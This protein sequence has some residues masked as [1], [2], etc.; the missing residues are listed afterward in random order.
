M[1][2]NTRELQCIARDIKF[3]NM[4]AARLERSTTSHRGM[5]TKFVNLAT[6]IIGMLQTCPSQRAVQKLECLK[7]QIDWKVEDIE[8][9]YD[10]LL[11][12]LDPE[13]DEY[14]RLNGLVS[15]TVARHADISKSVV[16]AAPGQA[17]GN[18]VKLKEGLKP[19]VL[20]LDF[21]PLEFQTWQNKFRIYYR[22]SRMNTANNKEQRSYFYSCISVHL[23]SVITRNTPTRATIFIEEGQQDESCF[24]G[25]AREFHK[26]TLSPHAASSFS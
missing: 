11:A 10:I 3:S 26:N 23:Q 12:D 14:K 22:T 24:E 21:S 4:D 19:T 1:Y 13:D 25:L 6:I 18:Q 7:Q 15:A 20:T 2:S 16:E 5:L 17:G 9:G 8:A